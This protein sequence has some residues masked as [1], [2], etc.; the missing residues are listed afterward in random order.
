MVHVPGD[1]GGVAAPAEGHLLPGVGRHLAPEHHAC[2]ERHCVQQ[3]SPALA[4]GWV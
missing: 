4:R 2:V 3:L 1:G